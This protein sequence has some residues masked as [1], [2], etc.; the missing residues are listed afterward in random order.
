MRA[1]IAPSVAEGLGTSPSAVALAYVLHQPGHVLPVV[2]TRSEAHLDE[3]L[4]AQRIRLHADEVA[5][6]ENGAPGP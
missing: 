4:A 5:W 6:L 3:A 1:G 2:G